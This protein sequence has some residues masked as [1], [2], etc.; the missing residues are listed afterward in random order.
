MAAPEGVEPSA[1]T[2][3]ASGPGP[4]AGL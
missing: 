3:V 2:F 4:Q 1:P